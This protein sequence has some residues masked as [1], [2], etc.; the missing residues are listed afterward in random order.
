MLNACVYRLQRP[1]RAA[2]VHVYAEDLALHFPLPIVLIGGQFHFD[3]LDA[4]QVVVEQACRVQLSDLVHDVL[5][6]VAVRPPRNGDRGCG[7]VNEWLPCC[8]TVAG[9]G[10]PKKG[11][12]EEQAAARRETRLDDWCH[13]TLRAVLLRTAPQEVSARWIA[14][15]AR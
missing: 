9:F 15:R 1:G 4:R 13:W 2:L 5:A 11:L 3:R 7:F 14:G 10:C 12:T 8:Y 6:L